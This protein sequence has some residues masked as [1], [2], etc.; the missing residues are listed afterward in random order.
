MRRDTH[1]AEARKDFGQHFHVARGAEAAHI[2]AKKRNSEH[3]EGALSG[4]G[5]QFV[6][7]Q[8]LVARHAD[9][10]AGGSNLGQMRV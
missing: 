8:D 1:V 10:A 6:V 9:T 3:N 4:G 7:G 5:A 2:A